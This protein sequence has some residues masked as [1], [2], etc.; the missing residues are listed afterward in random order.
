MAQI[1]GSLTRLYWN[2]PAV[3]DG[4]FAM[5]P[6]GTINTALWNDHSGRSLHELAVQTKVLAMAYLWC[7]H[8]L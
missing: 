2:R 6:D 3:T 4:T 8:K 5:N 7:I 1:S